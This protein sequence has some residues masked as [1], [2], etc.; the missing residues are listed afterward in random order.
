MRHCQFCC[1]GTCALVALGEGVLI[2]SEYNSRAKRIAMHIGQIG[3]AHIRGEF[4]G[5]VIFIGGGDCFRQVGLL[6]LIRRP[7][8]SRFA[9]QN[10]SGCYL[11]VA[12]LP[13]SLKNILQHAGTIGGTHATITR[14]KNEW[15]PSGA[16]GLEGDQ[17]AKTV[18]AKI[19]FQ[20]RELFCAVARLL[21]N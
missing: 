20:G 13:Y 21:S 3:F 1:A 16:T 10:P 5:P 14:H 12:Q 2:T 11:L 15:R 8:V 9:G 4:R 17:L 7:A 19:F 6:L 18:T